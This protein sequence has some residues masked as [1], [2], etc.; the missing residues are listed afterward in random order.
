MAHQIQRCPLSVER[1]D[2]QHKWRQSNAKI[3][4]DSLL[5]SF[6]ATESIIVK[7]FIDLMYILL[8][9]NLYGLHDTSCSI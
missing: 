3:A 2:E 6:P 9:N 1:A 7:Y 5:Y 8:L 4:D